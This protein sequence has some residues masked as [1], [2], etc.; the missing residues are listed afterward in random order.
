ME[1]SR[2]PNLLASLNLL[3]IQSMNAIS[4]QQERDSITEKSQSKIARR[5]KVLKRKG[6]RVRR[7]KP[8]CEKVSGVIVSEIYQSMT[9]DTFVCSLLL[10]AAIEFGGA[11]TVLGLDI[12]KQEIV[13]CLRWGEPKV[14]GVIVSEI[15]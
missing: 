13:A 8:R 11:G 12:A 14:S 4:N 15:Y 10:E 1:V 5:E 7:R 9:P 6:I 3:E 2:L